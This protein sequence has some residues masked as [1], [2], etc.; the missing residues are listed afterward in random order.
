M[1]TFIF[2]SVSAV[3]SF[4]TLYRLVDLCHSVHR[5]LLLSVR[6]LSVHHSLPF[7]GSEL[8]CP[9]FS[10]AVSPMSYS[11]SHCTFCWICLFY[12]TMSP[13]VF[14]ILSTVCQYLNLYL[15]L[16]CVTMSN[17]VFYRLSTLRQNVTPNRLLSLFH[18]VHICFVQSVHF[19]AVPHILLRVGSV[20]MTAAVYSLSTVSR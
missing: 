17:S 19:L 13:A 2:Y 7:Y 4:L 14:Y 9:L 5:C 3:F 15:L 8:L 6:C 1:Y 20:N 10:S 16:F 12:V 11:T 18:C